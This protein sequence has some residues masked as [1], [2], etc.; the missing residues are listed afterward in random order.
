MEGVKLMFGD[1]FQEIAH[2]ANEM[3]SSGVITYIGENYNIRTREEWR[4]L[5]KN[6]ENNDLVHECWLKK[7]I[8]EQNCYNFILD[9]IYKKSMEVVKNLA[10]QTWT[11]DIAD[12]D[13]ML[14]KCLEARLG[15]Y[16]RNLDCAQFIA[17]LNNS[18]HKE[19]ILKHGQAT[20]LLS[21]KTGFLT[22]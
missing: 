10:V 14:L 8:E 19:E 6:I 20:D 18:K 22:T 5:L 3:D 2:I 1:S 21:Q 16:V 12:E 7:L 13:S 4:F 9:T 11:P 17:G 15:K